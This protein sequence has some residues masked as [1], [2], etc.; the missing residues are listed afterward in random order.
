MQ[1]DSGDRHGR[2]LDAAE[3]SFTQAGFHRT[4]VQDV[5]REAGMS[6]GNLY[7]YFPSKDAIV[8]GL[9]ERDRMMLREDFESFAQAERLDL[10][11][12]ALAHKHFEEAPRAKAVLCLQIWAEAT[13]NPAIAEA[14]M[15]LENDLV[16]GIE[17]L[18]A[19]G[20]ARGEV[21]S[22]VD[23]VAT[24]Q[25]IMTMSSGLFVRRALFPDF[26][27]GSEIE[28]LLNVI[29]G[30]LRGDT[31]RGVVPHYSPLDT[32]MATETHR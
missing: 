1:A 31:L 21:A 25:L 19:A 27:A 29:R 5:A 8:A 15:T 16:H 30:V 7:R 4:T 9:V 2:I 32:V 10:V 28:T 26:D 18:I 3:R 23:A 24:A 11:L 14:N 20:Q 12:Q 13:V 6:P 22:G 17:R